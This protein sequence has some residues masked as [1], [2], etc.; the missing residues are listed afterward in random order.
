MNSLAFW[1][2]LTLL[3]LGA[4]VVVG[5]WTNDILPVLALLV[6]DAIFAA[7]MVRLSFESVQSHT[8]HNAC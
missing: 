7:Q 1:R 8:R 4:I 5:V 6:L 2:F 3:F